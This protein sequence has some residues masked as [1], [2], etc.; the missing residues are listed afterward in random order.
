MIRHVGRSSGRVYETPIMVFRRDGVAV[1]ALTYG[2]DAD[3]VR[4]VVAAG[5]CELVV[6][7][8]AT[9]WSRPEIVYTADVADRLPRIVCFALRLLR[10]DHFLRLSAV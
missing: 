9:S 7:H 10:A 8:C 2:P 5:G 4:N 1:I 3:W 6:R